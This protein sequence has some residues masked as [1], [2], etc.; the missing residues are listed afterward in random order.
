MCLSEK[1]V[2]LVSAGSCALHSSELAQSIDP[3]LLF[4]A[5]ISTVIG[6]ARYSTR[7]FLK[8]GWRR[9]Q[10]KHRTEILYNRVQVTPRRRSPSCH[11]SHSTSVCQSPF[12]LHTLQSFFPAQKFPPSVIGSCL[13][14]AG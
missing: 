1:P 9:H 3:S 5:V 7:A 4:F 12:I 10:D 13:W 8:S 2:S 6:C 11:L 14:S